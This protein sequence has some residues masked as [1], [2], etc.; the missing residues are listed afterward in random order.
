MLVVKRCFWCL[1]GLVSLL[2]GSS[3]PGRGRRIRVSGLDMELSTVSQTEMYLR[4]QRREYVPGHQSEDLCPVLPY[5]I[6]GS[7]VSIFRR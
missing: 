5:T 2:R 3:T 6:T 7:R 4:S 1:P